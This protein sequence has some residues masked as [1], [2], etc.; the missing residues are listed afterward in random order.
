[1]RKKFN[2]FRDFI[3]PG[4]SLELQNK[5]A[6]RIINKYE[7]NFKTLP[8]EV[9]LQELEQ[10]KQ[11]YIDIF[12]NISAYMA[13][14]YK[15]YEGKHLARVNYGYNAIVTDYVYY[16]IISGSRVDFY[17]DNTYTKKIPQ[18]LPFDDIDVIETPTAEDMAEADKNGESARLAYKLKD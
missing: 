1:M 11:Y 9:V 7:K 4:V 10:M 16:V 12:D 5:F 18:S 6:G 8:K 2:D 3:Y 13:E 17:T 14:K 15:I